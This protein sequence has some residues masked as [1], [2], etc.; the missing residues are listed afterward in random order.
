M[1]L[2]TPRTSAF[3]AMRE[4]AQD[5]GAL[6]VDARDDH[7]LTDAMRTLLTD[8]IELGRLTDQAARRPVRTW[9]SYAAEV[10]DL[11]TA[12]SSSPP[13]TI[14]VSEDDRR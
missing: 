1:A 4:I 12:P 9:D 7:A 6:L 13:A 11:L 8:D 3:G 2:T 10:W 5:G 14:G